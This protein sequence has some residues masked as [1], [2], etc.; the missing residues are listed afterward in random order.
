MNDPTIGV[1]F[2][3]C[4][5]A[6]TAHELTAITTSGRVATSSRASSGSLSGGPTRISTTRLPPSTYPCLASSGN[7]TERKDRNNGLVVLVGNVRTPSRQTL[8]GDCASAGAAA[9]TSNAV[10]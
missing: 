1:V 9:A 10:K 6:S 4:W 5:T 2:E 3:A 7:T 8:P